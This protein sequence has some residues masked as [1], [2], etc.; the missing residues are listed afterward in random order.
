M[1]LQDELQIAQDRLDQIR[2]SLQ[3]YDNIHIGSYSSSGNSVTYTLYKDL[4]TAE[5]KAF[6]RVQSIQSTIDGK[7]NS[8]IKPMARL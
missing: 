3:K 1:N 5:A 8:C 4:L 6:K 7:S 2:A